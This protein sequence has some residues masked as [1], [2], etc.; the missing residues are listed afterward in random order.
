MRRILPALLILFS[1]ELMAASKPAAKQISYPSGNETVAGTLYAPPGKGPFPALV[2]IHEW[3]G[4]NDWVKDQAQNLAGLGYVTLAVDLYR[5]KF[6]TNPEEAHELMRGLPDDRATRDLKAAVAYLKT[7]KNVDATKIGSIG[8]CM[9]GGWS[10]ILAE[11]EPTLKAAVI[12]YGRLSSDAETLKPIN[13]SILGLFGA[14]DRG[15]PP[16]SVEA[17]AKEMKELGKKVEVKIYSDAGHAFENPNNKEGYRPEDT[18]DAWERTKTFL[19]ENL[20]R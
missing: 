10:L 18:K 13:A 6:T 8:W 17:F 14:K 9:G 7:L 20:K 1:I 11:N 3:W 15:I 4:L 16:S 2:V 19:A 12:N 5:G